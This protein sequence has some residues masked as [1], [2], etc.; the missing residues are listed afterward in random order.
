M[1][2]SFILLI[3]NVDIQTLSFDI[4]SFQQCLSTYFKAI[5]INFKMNGVLKLK[6][7]HRKDNRSKTK[8]REYFETPCSF[9]YFTERDFT[10]KSRF[11]WI[12]V[13]IAWKT[14]NMEGLYCH[15]SRFYYIIWRKKIDTFGIG[16]HYNG[17][18]MQDVSCTKC[19]RQ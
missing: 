2:F 14:V 18:L 6:D 17:F 12:L 8:C 3:L 19:L 15:H 16:S 1:F 11:W 4:Y 9:R 5:D 7:S 13:K 10:Q